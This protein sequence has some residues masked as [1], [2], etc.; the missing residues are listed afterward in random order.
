MAHALQY[1]CFLQH[2]ATTMLSSTCPAVCL[3]TGQVVLSSVCCCSISFLFPFDFDASP[4]GVCDM[5]AT[6]RAAA[7]VGVVSTLDRAA[8]TSVPVA[9][10]L[11]SV[12]STVGGSDGASIEEVLTARC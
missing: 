6:A 11:A 7:S 12:P 8:T 3:Q 1:S 10:L 5:L 2:G 4:A 9:L